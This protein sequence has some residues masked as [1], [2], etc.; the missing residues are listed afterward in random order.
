MPSTRA[1]V[2]TNVRKS[3][4]F[5]KAAASSPME[6]TV[7]VRDGANL[8]ESRWILFISW[9]SVAG[10]LRADI[11]SG[12]YGD[13]LVGIPFPMASQNEGNVQNLLHFFYRHNFHELA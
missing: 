12:R 6:R 10:E 7:R 1:S 2:E 9:I 11:I 5:L 13:F 8:E 3:L 4:A